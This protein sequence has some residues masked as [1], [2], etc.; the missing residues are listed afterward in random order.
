MAVELLK[1][2]SRF[3]LFMP[4]AADLT[5]YFNDIHS[6]KE[7]YARYNTMG[8]WCERNEHGKEKVVKKTNVVVKV[9]DFGSILLYS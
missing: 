5:N 2:F 9:D 3:V 6:S 7:F 4:Y 8:K 1:V